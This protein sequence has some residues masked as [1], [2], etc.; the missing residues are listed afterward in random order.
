MKYISLDVEATSLLKDSKIN[1]LAPQILQLGAVIEDTHNIKSFTDIPKYI[2]Y[3]KHPIYIG[4]AFA[5]QMN[6]KI[7]KVLAGVIEPEVGAKILNHWEVAVDFSNWLKENGFEVEKDKIYITV[8]GKNVNYDLTCLNK[9][10]KWEDLISVRHRVLDPATSF[11][12]WFN[13]DVPPNFE[14]CKK[15]AGFSGEV[16]HHGLIDAWE[17]VLMLRRLYNDD[18]K[19]IIWG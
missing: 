1:P 19:M 18:L 17:V 14:T 7:M 3:V 16:A 15:R 6:N 11:T 10:P 9:L 8:A 2:C 13:D 4:S 12:D 5:L